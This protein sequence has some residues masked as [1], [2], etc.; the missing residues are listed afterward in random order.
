MATGSPSPSPRGSP[1]PSPEPLTVTDTV[2]WWSEWLT[3][4]APFRLVG[5]IVFAAIVNWLLDRLVRR[6]VARTET[7]DA[8]RLHLF[9]RSTT[10]GADATVG[11]QQE[12]RRQRAHAIGQLV[13]SVIAAVVW[14]TAILMILPVLG[15]DITP[16]L[17]SAGVIG[18]ALGFGAQTLVK[19]YL[20]GI[21]MIIE[22]Q[23]GVG[24]F[25][26]L[27]EATGTVEEVTLRVTRLRDQ[28]GVVWYVRNGEIMRVGNRSQGWTLAVVDIAVPYDQDLT[29]VQHIV[30]SVADELVTDPESGIGEFSRP[31]YA[32]I[33]SV[34]GD[35]LTI[36]VVA[37]TDAD[38]QVP[39]TREIRRRLKSAFDQAGITVP[40]VYRPPIA[41]PPGTSASRASRP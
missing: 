19:D 36:R 10:P 22:D 6:L 2:T 3:S 38:H 30:E 21:F 1:S 17:A 13:R 29:E 33:E 8:S 24:D 37:K 4:G 12:R 31:T 16:L 7:L 9:Q 23:F 14:G 39:L 11:L 15:I 41:A 25:V 34:A 40:I 18:V 27:G 28:Q 32:G 26:D 5:I 20:S 35:G